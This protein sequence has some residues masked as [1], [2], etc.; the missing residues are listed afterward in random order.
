MSTRASVRANLTDA[1]FADARRRKPHSIAER[2]ADR[3]W[4][5]CVRR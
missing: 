3:T 1:L 4:C 5:I 2:Y